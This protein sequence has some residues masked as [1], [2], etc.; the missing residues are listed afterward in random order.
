MAKFRPHKNVLRLLGVCSVNG[1]KI[2]IWY[3]LV[4]MSV[5][6]HR[7]PLAYRRVRATWKLEGLLALETEIP[8][9][10]AV[11]FEFESIQRRFVEVDR[12]WLSHERRH[13][14]FEFKR[15]LVWRKRR[16]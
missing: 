1:T 16:V 13:E 5:Y 14:H 7:S 10:F 9:C 4:P 6:L 12:V 3:L 15:D 2:N 11:R 8:R